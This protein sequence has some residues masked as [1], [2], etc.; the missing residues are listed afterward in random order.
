MV[1]WIIYYVADQELLP[2]LSRLYGRCYFFSMMKTHQ[3]IAAVRGM[4]LLLGIE[5]VWDRV[6]KAPAKEVAQAVLYQ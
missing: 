4:G 2:K 1:I 3:Y 6:S 5:F